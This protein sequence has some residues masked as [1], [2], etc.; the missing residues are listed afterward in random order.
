ML[1]VSSDSPSVLSESLSLSKRSADSVTNEEFGDAWFCG[2]GGKDGVVLGEKDGSQEP[3][4]GIP[5]R[6]HVLFTKEVRRNAAG[7]MSDC[8]RCEF[9]VPNVPQKH[10][11]KLPQLAHYFLR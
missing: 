4:D 1:C 3:L 2:R 11:L 5:P 6:E 8:S 9:S 7:G 10:K